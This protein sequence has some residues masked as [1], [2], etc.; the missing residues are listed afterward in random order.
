MYSVVT[1]GF[2]PNGSI[3]EIITHGFPLRGQAG[4]IVLSFN[5]TITRNCNLTVIS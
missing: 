5:V 2:W 1:Y 3:Y 4:G